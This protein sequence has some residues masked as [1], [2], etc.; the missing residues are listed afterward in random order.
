MLKYTLYIFILL[1]F[2]FSNEIS[3]STIELEGEYEKRYTSTLNSVLGPE[4]F[5]IEV[6]AVLKKEDVENVSNE[7]PINFLPGLGIKTKSIPKEIKSNNKNPNASIESLNINL[8]LE[9]TLSDS[10]VNI[11]TQTIKNHIL[12]KK[13]KNNLIINRVQLYKSPE[14]LPVDVVWPINTYDPEEEKKSLFSDK[15]I[16]G[17]FFV[18]LFI[19]IAVIILLI[20][21]NKLYKKFIDFSQSQL[22]GQ[23]AVRLAL[24]EGL[25]S[26]ELLQEES[27]IDKDKKEESQSNIQQE[28]QNAINQNMPTTNP[29]G[30]FNSDLENTFREVGSDI[31]DAISNIAE[32]VTTSVKEAISESTSLELQHQNPFDFISFLDIDLNKKVFMGENEGSSAIVLSHLEPKKASEILSSLDVDTKLKIA[33]HMATM[34]GTSKE[35]LNSVKTKFRNKVKELLKPDFNPI[36]GVN[37]LSNILNEMDQDDSESIL[38]SISQTNK[39]IS[40]NIRKNI[41]YF[42]DILSLTNDQIDSLINEIDINTL[43]NSLIN[44]EENIKNKIFNSLSTSGQS[45]LKRRI[46][47]LDNTDSNSIQISQKKVGEKI[48]ALIGK[49]NE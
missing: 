17:S 47:L 1:N 11:A 36:N 28:V 14:I 10:L 40:D 25:S 20:F 7:I 30:G 27:I 24:E 23:D 19:V 16:I 4:N 33:Q 37:V 41:G 29:E 13:I 18:G 38:F 21:I 46:Q 49:H 3:I 43:A 44:C 8:N 42:N 9:T 22:E 39:T 31:I 12:Y 35:I 48:V 15:S 45:A 6:N 32:P 2:S 26:S 5:Y 34:E